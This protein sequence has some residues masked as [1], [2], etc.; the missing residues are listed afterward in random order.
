MYLLLPLL[1][2]D[3]FGTVAAE[4]EVNELARQSKEVKNKRGFESFEIIA[5]CCSFDGLRK[6][7]SYLKNLMQETSGNAFSR[8]MADVLTRV[9]RGAIVNFALNPVPLMKLITELIEGTGF[10]FE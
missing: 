2:T 7:L 1:L 3:V 10:Y 6:I 5:S 4:K 8:N 9:A